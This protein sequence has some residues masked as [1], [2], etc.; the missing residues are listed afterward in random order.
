MTDKKSVIWRIIRTSS[1]MRILIYF[2]LFCLMIAVFTVIFHNIYPQYEGI[3]VDWSESFLFVIQ[4]FTTTGSMLPITSD[5]MTLFSSFTM[6]TGVVMLFMVIPLFLT[7]YIVAVLKSTPLKKI[8]RRL[9]GH[10]VIFGYG[11]LAGTLVKSLVISDRDIVIIE[12]DE[13]KAGEISRENLR[14]AYVLWGEYDNHATWEK[15]GIRTADYVI[16]C[17]KEKPAAN[18][19]LGMRPLTRARIISVVDRLSFERYMRYAGSDYVVS[20]KH[21]TGRILARHTV[22]GPGVAMDL[23]VPGLDRL[24][25]E[26]DDPKKELRFIHVPVLS[27]SPAVGKTLRDLDLLKKYGVI[28]P[29]LWRQGEFI[30]DPDP[31]IMLDR[32]SSLFI[33]G[34]AGEVSRVIS[35]VFGA[36]RVE[37]GHAVIAG[38][39][40]V[41]SA[42]YNELVASGIPC[43]VIDAVPHDIDQVTGNA[44]DEETLKAA[45]IAEA[46]FMV[47][48]LGSDDVNIF[49]TLMARNLNPDIRILAR[50]NETSSVDR[51]YRAG[52]D[53]VALQ[54]RIGGQT[55]AR[56]VLEGTLT[57][58]IDLPNGEM[59]ALKQVNFRGV[60]M[61][62][63]IA[64]DSGVTI[65]GI[66]APSRVIVAPSGN[67]EIR[68]GDTLIVVGDSRRLKKFIRIL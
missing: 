32:S 52:A 25:L 24:T 39:G 53:Y 36:G 56:I 9:S 61:V 4:T 22:A 21:V 65:L 64:E 43:V 41:G 33:F 7:P 3:P 1:E 49:A 66:E 23:A 19:I 11:E 30:S 47:V 63:E 38:F 68:G 58:M 42:A 8:P 51:L 12:K 26:T 29:C 18:L 59:V 35:E 16:I 10:I 27:G 37:S 45:R 31:G 20:P 44:E 50:A 62:R 28:V 14:Q 6:L 2:I 67:Q 34:R 40:D 13:Q 55:I 17:E 15:A 57:V 46:R 48:T 5:Q 54:P 60:R